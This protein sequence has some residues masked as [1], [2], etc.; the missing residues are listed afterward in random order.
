[1]FALD[2][3]LSAYPPRALLLC[4]FKPTVVRSLYQLGGALQHVV[5]FSEYEVTA[6]EKDLARL[7]PRTCIDREHRYMQACISTRC[8]RCFSPENSAMINTRFSIGYL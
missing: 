4:Q 2:H 6:T 5:E 7:Q 1:M 8:N 3:L